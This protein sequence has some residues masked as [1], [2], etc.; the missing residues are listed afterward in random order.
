MDLKQ[1]NDLLLRVIELVFSMLAYDVA[2]SGGPTVINSRIL[3]AG[4]LMVQIRESI[5]GHIIQSQ[6]GIFIYRINNE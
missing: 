2:M 1:F 6:K 4:S 3:Y 5:Q